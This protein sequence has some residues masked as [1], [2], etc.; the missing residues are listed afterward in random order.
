MTQSTAA[1]AR[2]R[3]AGIVGAAIVAHAPQ[4]LSLPVSEDL[5]QVARVKAAM[6][7]VGDGLRALEPDLVIVISNTHGEELVFHCV[8]PFAIHCGD[9]AQGRDGHKGW[10]AIDGEAG[11]A[12]TEHLYDEGFDP[13]FSMDLEVGTAFT[14]PHE[15]CGF[16]REQAF[17]PIFI[18][19]YTPPQPRPER[20]FAFGRALARSLER[21][22]RRA[23]VIASGGLSHY[24]AT[25]MYPKPDLVTDREIFQKIAAGNLLHVMSFDAARLD[26]SG[27]VENRALQI[28]AGAIGDHVPDLAVFEPSWHHIYAIAG[29]T[30]GLAE[31]S[32][33]P[34]YPG[35]RASYSSLGRAIHTLVVS[36]AA[37]AD[38]LADRQAYAMRYALPED[39]VEALIALDEDVLRERYSINPMMTYQAKNRT[40]GKLK[41]RERPVSA[42]SPSR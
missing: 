35:F 41:N 2:P 11:A 15:F 29:W 31:S 10:W 9:R 7:T 25:P 17:L 34:L 32:Y 38:F 40:G 1:S 21:M 27:N 26:R 28:L 6:Q 19:A 13:A 14:I 39:Q 12:L 8:P 36:D 18:N 23:V 16:S 30:S 5:D 37:V 20:C 33:V 22:G 24:P 42:G 3:E 4:F